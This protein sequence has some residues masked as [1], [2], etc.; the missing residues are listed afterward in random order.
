MRLD[1]ATEE[2][3]TA[4]FNSAHG[5]STAAHITLR[6]PLLRQVR[7]K[8]QRNVLVW[9]LSMKAAKTQTQEA[10]WASELAVAEQ[11]MATD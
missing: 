8:M 4:H 11:E 1:E 3:A 5:I 6:R 7:H 2:I 10:M 9:R